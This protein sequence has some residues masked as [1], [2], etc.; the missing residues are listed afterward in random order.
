MNFALYYPAK[1]FITAQAWGIYNPAYLQFGFDHHNGIDF[2][3]EP[4]SL[5]HCPAEFTVVET[6]FNAG[7]G[8]FVRL[9]TPVKYSVLGAECYIGAML[10]HFKE[11]QVKAGDTLKIGDVL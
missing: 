6:G 8:N 9:V 11:V 5:V 10:M 2:T 1:P 3:L 7:A 4:D